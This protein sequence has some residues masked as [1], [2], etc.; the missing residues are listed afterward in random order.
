MVHVTEDPVFIVSVEGSNAKFLI[1]MAFPV[2]VVA[3]IDD[4]V[5]GVWLEVQ[6]AVMQARTMSTKQA[7]QK[8]RRECAGILP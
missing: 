6:P 4:G 7:M 1:R 8:T 3:G 2:P 5:G